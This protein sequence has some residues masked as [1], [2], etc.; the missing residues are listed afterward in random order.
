GNSADIVDATTFA[1]GLN[2][3][4]KDRVNLIINKNGTT[5]TNNTTYNLVASEDWN[6]GAD[7]AV[8]IVDATSPITVSN[9]AVPAIAS[10]SYNASTGVLTAT[11]S[12]FLSA[13]G[14]NNDIDA[15]KLTFVGEGGAY[16]L[17]GNSV[18]VI[19]TT[20]FAIGLNA[21]DKNAINLIFNKN[22]NTSTNGTT[23][24]LVASEDWNTGA[25]A[26]VNIVDAVSTV[27]VTNVSIPTIASVSYDAA[28]GVLTATG[29]GFLAASGSNNDINALKLTFI[30]EGSAHTLTGGSVDIIDATTFAIGL[31]ATDKSAINLIFNKNG[32]SS[33]NTIAYNMIASEDWNAGADAAVTIVD[34]VTPITVSNVAVPTIASVSYDAAT[35]VLTATGSGFLSA[36]GANNDINALKLTFVGEGGAYTLTGNSA[37]IVDATTFA[38]GLNATD[39]DRVNLIINKNGTTSTNNT[40]YNLVASE[41]WNAGADAAVTIVDAVSPITAVNVA[42]PAIASVSYNASAGI[43]TATG[44]GFLS[45]S[46]SNNDIDALKLTFVGEGGAYT[47]TGNSVDVI[48]TTSFAIGLNATDKN[49]I[50]LIFNK[51]GN[52]S[53]N[54]TT[55]NLVASEDWNAGADA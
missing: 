21:T 5:S 7:A 20:S 42:V 2:A 6:A 32:S 27:N 33:T 29:S 26:A 17:T 40:T 8:T 51:N 35:G 12:G 47:L 50:N 53:T 24:N 9:V 46:G 18:D 41:D 34:A 45:A 31:N 48:S 37:D 28:S 4:D 38:I 1:I 3:T 52:S 49:A 43:L 13:S 23:Y 11:G 55:Y 25:D 16:T 10:V 44:S 54:G 36:S 30:G 22:G 39:K 15:L 19:S 14:S